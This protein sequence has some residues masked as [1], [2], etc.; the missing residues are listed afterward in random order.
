[1]S[2]YVVIGHVKVYSKKFSDLVRIL[3]TYT[4]LVSIAYRKKNINFSNI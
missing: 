4:C 2:C 3:R 1:M